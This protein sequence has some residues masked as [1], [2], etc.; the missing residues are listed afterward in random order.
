MI[1][2]Q[3]LDQSASL[4]TYDFSFTFYILQSRVWLIRHPGLKVVCDKTKLVGFLFEKE[5]D[6]PLLVI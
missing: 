3:S 4:V 1:D 2:R 5:P 6:V